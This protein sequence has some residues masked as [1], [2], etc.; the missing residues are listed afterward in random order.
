M[1]VYKKSNNIRIIWRTG[2]ICIYYI[3]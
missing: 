2:K 3:Y 1:K